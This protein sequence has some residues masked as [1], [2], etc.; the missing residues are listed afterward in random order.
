MAIE[1]PSNGTILGEISAGGTIIG[2]MIGQRGLQGIQGVQGEKGDT[3]DKGDKGDTGSTGATGNGISSITKTGTSGYVDTYT[4]AYTD[5]TST[6]FDV[7]NGEVSQAELPNC[8]EANR[9]ES[10]CLIP[11]STAR[12]LPIGLQRKSVVLPHSARHRLR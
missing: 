12:V 3:G 10:M 5:G 4:I 6:T 2:G 9:C 11:I 7:T 1:I 8:T